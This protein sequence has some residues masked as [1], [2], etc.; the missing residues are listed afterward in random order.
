MVAGIGRLGAGAVGLFE[1]LEMTDLR[2]VKSAK[3]GGRDERGRFLRGRSGNPAG[4]PRG[5]LDHA[6][7]AAQVLLAGEGAALTRRAIELALDGDPAAMRLCLERV[8]GPCRERAVEFEMP[9]IRS[10]DD[11]APAMSA[12]A[13]ATAQA[14]IT[15]REAMQLGQVFE[16]YIRAVEATEF[17]RRLKALELA[18]A[19]A[20]SA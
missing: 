5:C 14:A 15:P 17:E 9:P 1:E 2:V 16:A 13:T 18:D 6:N 20:A 3:K 4:R 19:A 11:L 12:V 7:R 10:A 8:L